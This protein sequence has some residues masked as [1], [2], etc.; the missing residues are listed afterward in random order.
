[1]SATSS[2]SI[3]SD[4]RSSTPPRTCASTCKQLDVMLMLRLMCGW[5]DQQHQHAFCW[6]RVCVWYDS[7]APDVFGDAARR[8]QRVRHHHES[9]EAAAA[10]RHGL[11]AVVS[12]CCYCARHDQGLIGMGCRQLCLIDYWCHH[13]DADQLD[14]MPS[15]L[16]T[17]ALLSL[18]CVYSE[19]L[20]L[21]TTQP[22]KHCCEQQTN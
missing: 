18:R 15:W 2:A 10:L 6:V 11:L 19:L 16:T 21:L 4:T 3:V 17:H 14:L 22:R 7:D 13:H 8:L 12:D 1:M 9:D 20:H 5:C